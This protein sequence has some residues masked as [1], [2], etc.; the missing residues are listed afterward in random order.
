M[1]SMLPYQ[2]H[3]KYRHE[4][5]ISMDGDDSWMDVVMASWLKAKNHQKLK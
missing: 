5:L 3:H 1:L 4:M 2:L